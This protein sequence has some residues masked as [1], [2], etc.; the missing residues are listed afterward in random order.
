M[1]FVEIH[2]FIDNQQRIKTKNTLFF[3]KRLSSNDLFFSPLGWTSIKCTF[4][5]K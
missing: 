2:E 1:R 4:P 3:K 5:K